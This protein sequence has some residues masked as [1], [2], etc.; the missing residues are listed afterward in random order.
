MKLVLVVDD[1][2]VIRKVA[3]RI[4]EGL[5]LRTCEAADAGGALA[6]CQR[7]MPDAILLD[8]RIP[9]ADSVEFLAALRRMPGGST[10]KVV[11]CASE[12]D[13]GHIAR[14]LRAGA[15]DYM[16]KPFDQKLLRAKFEALGFV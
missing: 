10:P 11:L 16:L 3:R 4:L 7:R 2:T 6:E 13:A 15:D 9:G 12:N 1:S 14:A 5:H 8:W